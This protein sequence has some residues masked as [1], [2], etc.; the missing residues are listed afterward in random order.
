MRR[1]TT[2]YAVFIIFF[3]AALTVTDAH[4]WS[5]QRKEDAPKVSEKS[6]EELVRKNLR[7]REELSS[8]AEEY[9]EIKE[10]RRLLVE[11]IKALQ[12][13]RDAFTEERRFLEADLAGQKKKFFELEVLLKERDSETTERINSDLNAKYARK[14]SELEKSLKAAE[15]KTLKSERDK[16]QLEEKLEGELKTAAGRRREEAARIKA[17]KAD[18][19]RL[20][21]EAKKAER[22]QEKMAKNEKLR[23]EE[24]VKERLN[25]HYNLAVAFDMHGMYGDAEREYLKCLKID[26]LDAGVH[27]NLGILYDDK[28]N[29][30]NKAMIYYKNFLRLRPKGEDAIQVREWLLN[31]E[32]AQRIGTE[33][34]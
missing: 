1:K 22:V 17:L 26:P 6:Y 18:K 29:Q 11:K 24:L 5:W 19:E 3:T 23:K 20:A 4:A 7:L 25:M 13:T 31:V 15:D 2:L 28:L 8:L 30:D 14:I 32:Q 21:A 27:Y 10:M 16:D 12:Q 9:G 34:R 33:I